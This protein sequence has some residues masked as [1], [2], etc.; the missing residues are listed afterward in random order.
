MISG[1]DAHRY[2]SLAYIRRC[3]G[4]TNWSASP[5]GLFASRLGRSRRGRRTDQ[6]RGPR[7]GPR[8][9]GEPFRRNYSVRQRRSPCRPREWKNLHRAS[10]S[11]AVFLARNL[12]P[13]Y[14][15]FI[16][17]LGRPPLTLSCSVLVS[18]FISLNPLSLF[19]LS[20]FSSSLTPFS[21]F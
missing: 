3:S 5:G 2:I 9:R 18:F 14:S 13:H 7:R 15:A 16:S 8:D 20:L 1:V 11:H 12:R 4:G 17:G 19:V 10:I 6:L 21:F